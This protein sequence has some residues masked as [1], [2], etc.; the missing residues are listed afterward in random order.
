MSA[1]AGRRGWVLAMAIASLAGMVGIGAPGAPDA[2]AGGAA[3]PRRAPSLQDSPGYIPPED[4]E[5]GSVAVGRRPNAPSV[6][7]PLR[8]GLRSL[9]QLGRAICW[10][11]HHEDADTLLELAVTDQEFRDILWREFPQSR[12]ATGLTWQDAWGPLAARLGSGCRG[13]VSDDGGRY[14]S[15]VRFERGDT[16]AA[17]RNFKLHNGLVLVA[18]NDRGDEERFTWLRSVVE[19]GGRFK[20]YSVRD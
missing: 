5:A 6:R 18:T 2:T 9:D 20:I 11:L 12:P 8:G 17:Y 19:R 10:A 16:V 7:A 13:A 14:L 4:P 15:F 1:F 3:A